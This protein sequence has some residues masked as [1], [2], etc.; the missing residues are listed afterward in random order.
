MFQG[1]YEENALFVQKVHFRGFSAN[2][3]IESKS[4]GND[5]GYFSDVD[6]KAC[7]KISKY[8]S[9]PGNFA[10]EP[11]HKAPQPP[12]AVAKYIF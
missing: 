12:P 4:H 9:N 11:P 1:N 2:L 7:T 6:F 3:K 10:G 5:T 8:V